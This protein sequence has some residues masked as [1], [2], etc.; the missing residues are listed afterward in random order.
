MVLLTYTDPF[1]LDD[2]TVIGCKDDMIGLVDAAAAEFFAATGTP[3]TGEN[4]AKV[5]DFIQAQILSMEP[6]EKIEIGM[7]TIIAVSNA[8]YQREYADRVN[9]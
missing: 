8:Q 6:G 7:I 2:L 4:L 3:E 1:F 9:N 5:S